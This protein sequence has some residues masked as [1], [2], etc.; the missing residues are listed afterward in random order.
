MG[1]TS[2]C[3][4]AQ[5]L[6][7]IVEARAQRPA[8]APPASHSAARGAHGSRME[9]APRAPAE[10]AAEPAEVEPEV[11]PHEEFSVEEQAEE[12]EEAG[13]NKN[14]ENQFSIEESKLGK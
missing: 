2:P 13:R 3:S 12:V 5:V 10:P 4:A 11:E 6:R 7:P 9:E 14:Q 1:P 8:E